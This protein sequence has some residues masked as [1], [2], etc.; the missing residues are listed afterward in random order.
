M[1]VTP[2]FPPEDE[3][4]GGAD[5]DDPAAMVEML[6]EKIAPFFGEN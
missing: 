1:A 4:R 2:D 6:V 5:G 3:K